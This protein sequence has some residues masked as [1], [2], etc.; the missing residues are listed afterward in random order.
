MAKIVVRPIDKGLHTDR[1]AFNLD[2]DSFP[3]LI[4]AYQWRGRVKRKRGTSN[5]TRLTRFFNSTSTAYSSTSTIS[6]VAG[7]ANLFSGFSLQINGAIVPGSVIII[8]T[9]TSTTYTDPAKN[10]T[11]SGGSGGTINYATGAIT[12]TGG[13][14]DSI[15]AQF[16]YFPDLPVMGLEDLNLQANVFPG[17]LG[18]DTVYSY[19][20]PTSFPYTA[21]D[22]SFYKNPPTATYVGYI[23]KSIVTPTTWN[24]QD[25]QQFWSTNYQGAFWVTNGI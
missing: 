10:G 1:L 18:F 2:N 24:G 22:V 11:L 16:L 13:G 5:L 4:N 7:A 23:A 20:I 19:N 25:Y 14:T 3:T 21:Y 6:L 9:T 8:D 15:S 12:I 17:T